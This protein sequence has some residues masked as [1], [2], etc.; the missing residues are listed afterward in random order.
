MASYRGLG[1][2]ISMSLSLLCS[3][4]MTLI[5]CEVDMRQL[6]Y[7]RCILRCFEALSSLKVNFAKNEIFKVGDVDDIQALANILG[8]K[9]GVW[10]TSY[11][12]L[13]LAAKF[14]SKAV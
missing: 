10:P 9:V 5:F 13:P 14:K 7:W 4:L 8:C 11:L 2:G 1:L 3:M 6:G 12:G